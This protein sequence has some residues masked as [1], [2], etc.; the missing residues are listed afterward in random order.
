MNSI[1]PFLSRFSSPN[2]QIRVEEKDGWNFV[3]ITD[4]F[5]SLRANQRILYLDLLESVFTQCKEV[6]LSQKVDQWQ[7]NVGD[8]KKFANGIQENFSA[9]VSLSKDFDFPNLP[10]SDNREFVLHTI[11]PFNRGMW[12]EIVRFGMFNLP[13]FAYSLDGFIDTSP[14]SLFDINKVIVNWFNLKMGDGEFAKILKTAS[15]LFLTIDSH[16]CFF[17]SNDKEFDKLMETLN[18][19]S[20]K[21]SLKPVIKQSTIQS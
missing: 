5:S 1:K 18:R 17:V 19:L 10:D 9:K 3:E 6:Y 16:L 4:H 15:P 2:W 21:H 7:W 11:S 13:N 14:N 12:Q 8:C 20:E